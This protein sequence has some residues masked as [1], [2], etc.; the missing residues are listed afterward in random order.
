MAAFEKPRWIPLDESSLDPDPFV[1]FEKWWEEAVAVV[2]EPEAICIATAD[3]SGQPSARM[4]LLRGRDQRGFCFYTNYSS[5]KGQDLEENPKAALLWYVDPL[6]RQVRIEGRVER[7]SDEESDAYFAS[8]PRGHQLGA[9]ASHQSDP[10]E[11]RSAL[12]DEVVAVTERFEGRDVPR[13][14]HWGG[15][16]L[17]PAFFE[18]WQHREDRLHDRVFYEPLPGGGWSRTRHQP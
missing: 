13:P 17:V 12:Q 7:V 4:V 9:H 10:I 15:Y 5:H 8:R 3:A 14:E 6:G 1:Q 16:R 11:S 18:F 2:R